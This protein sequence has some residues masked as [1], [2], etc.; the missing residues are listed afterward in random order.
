MATN[1]RI[2]EERDVHPKI[3][4]QL[5]PVSRVPWVWVAIV[6]AGAILLALMIWLPRTPRGSSPSGAQMPQQPTGQQIQFTDLKLTPTPTGGSAYLDGKLVN[7]GPTAINGVLVEVAFKG[8]DGRTLETVRRPVEG[9][10]GGT[11]TTTQNLTEAPIKPGEG[12]HVRLALDRVPQGGNQQIPS[13]SVVAVTGVGNATDNKLNS[14]I[15]NKGQNASPS[16]SKI[17]GSATEPTPSN[18]KSGG[19]PQH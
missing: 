19:K 10:V 17:E 2:P 13:V 16:E 9:L 12:R 3:E 15:L 11:N 18:A 1:P 5:Q 14:P 6:A 8:S 4:Q 7:A